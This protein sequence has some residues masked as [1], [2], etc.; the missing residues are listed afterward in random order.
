QPLR[1]LRGE[2]VQHGG[3]AVGI[4]AERRRQQTLGA[5]NAGAEVVDLHAHGST[6]ESSMRVVIRACP[7]KHM[8]R[9]SEN[10]P[11]SSTTMAGRPHVR[12]SVTPP[13]STGARQARCGIPCPDTGGSCR[14]KPARP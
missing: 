5:T 4:H 13:L 10:Q 8:T 6:S 7:A 9:T 2:E 12:H 11:Y 1:G 14:V 3:R